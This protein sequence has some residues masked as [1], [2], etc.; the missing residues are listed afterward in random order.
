MDH[1]RDE[2]MAQKVFFLQKVL[3]QIDALDRLMKL[4]LIWTLRMIFMV[5]LNGVMRIGI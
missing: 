1:G 2:S 4:L 5:N 3:S